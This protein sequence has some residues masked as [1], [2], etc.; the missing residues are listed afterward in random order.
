MPL[1]PVHADRPHRRGGENR[2]HHQALDERRAVRFVGNAGVLVDVRDR[3][4]LPIEHGPA[5]DAGAH[6]EALAFPQW[7]D[8]V[9]LRVVATIALA[10]HEARPIGA[11]QLACGV[12]YDVHDRV[13]VARQGK[14]LDRGDQI[15]Q[16]AHM[17]L[18]GVVLPA[19]LDVP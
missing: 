1:R 11:D 16:V 14:R 7:R 17:A 8:G 2:R 4:R 10:Q 9:L 15:P 13:Q 12:A 19:G 5:A 6:G 18:A 3:R